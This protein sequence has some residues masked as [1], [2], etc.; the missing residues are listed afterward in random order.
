MIFL[1]SFYTLIILLL[2]YLEDKKILK[3]LSVIYVTILS[4]IG[5]ILFEFFKTPF[6]VFIIFEAITI[7]M[8]AIVSK[9]FDINILCKFVSYFPLVFL[10]YFS[11]QYESHLILTY[12]I[13][14]ILNVSM[15]IAKGNK[16]LKVMMISFNIYSLLTL[17]TVHSFK[18]DSMYSA[19]IFSILILK[20]MFTGF[21]FSRL[22]YGIIYVLLGVSLVSLNH[23][24]FFRYSI[25]MLFLVYLMLSFFKNLVAKVTFNNIVLLMICLS[26]IPIMKGHLLPSVVGVLAL[27]YKNYIDYRKMELLNG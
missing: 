18:I 17:S 13:I 25:V 5:M 11:N 9:K 23:L 21:K 20:L 26:I 16:S 7:S 27:M 1:F 24:D 6:D 12:A 15:V 14:N 3:D 4:F 19:I 2:S 10:N 22:S 8:Y